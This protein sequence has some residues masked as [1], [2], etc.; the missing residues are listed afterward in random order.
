MN[1]YVTVL[2]NIVSQE[3]YEHIIKWPDYIQGV[4]WRLYYKPIK[5]NNPLYVKNGFYFYAVSQEITTEWNDNSKIEVMCR[6]LADHNGI[7]KMIFGSGSA[8]ITPDLDDYIEVLS[9]LNELVDTYCD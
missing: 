1:K 9:S 6:G 4:H 5:N 8:L 2:K 7:N 3:N